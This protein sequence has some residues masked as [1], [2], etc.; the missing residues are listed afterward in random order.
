[1]SEN[2]LNKIYY[3]LESMKRNH[4]L[5]KDEHFCIIL[6]SEEW[7]TLMINPNISPHLRLDCHTHDDYLWN[8]KLLRVNK[9]S[10]LSISVE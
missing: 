2:I 4:R 8:F 7:N 5:S 10:H 6:G 9:P 3:S 1:M